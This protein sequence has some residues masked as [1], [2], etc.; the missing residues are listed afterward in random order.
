MNF[1]VLGFPLRVARSD[2]NRRIS[3]SVSPNNSSN[4]VLRFGFRA[5]SWLEAMSRLMSA[6]WT[7]LKVKTLA[8]GS[9]TSFHAM[10]EQQPFLGDQIGD[11]HKLPLAGSRIWGDRVPRLTH[12]DPQFDVP[13]AGDRDLRQL[14]VPPSP[15]LISSNRVLLPT[16]TGA[17]QHGQGREVDR[18]VA[19]SRQR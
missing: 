10:V 9:F 6:C 15:Y 1:E 12:G 18:A 19:R 11:S 17:G 2:R 7:Y 13:D 8:K 4:T 5:Y 16:P 3:A 14:I